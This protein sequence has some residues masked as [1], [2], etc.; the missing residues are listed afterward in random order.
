M[1]VGKG[2]DRLNV[3]GLYLALIKMSDEDMIVNM[4]ASQISL[5]LDIS[6][7]KIGKML[8]ELENRKLISFFGASH[9]SQSYVQMR[10]NIIP[11][12]GMDILLNEHGCS[13]NKQACSLNK[14]ACSLN[15][16]QLIPHAPMVLHEKKKEEEDDPRHRRR[17]QFFEDNVEL[18]VIWGHYRHNPST[19]QGRDM[20][21]TIELWPKVVEKVGIPAIIEHFELFNELNTSPKTPRFVVQLNRL[22]TRIVL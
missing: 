3:F 22:M 9:S 13:L 19:D 21:E 2:L 1:G 4:S 6:R 15:E 17:R 7:G 14:Q 8:K 18:K 11:L 10:L 20:D 12:K 16:Q 5:R